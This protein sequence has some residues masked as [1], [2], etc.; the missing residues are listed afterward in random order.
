MLSKLIESWL[1]SASE[2]SYQPAFCQMLI[3][4][5]YTVIHSTRH[6]PIEYGKDVLAIASD[7]IPC[8]FQLKGNP[9][10]SLTLSQY[11]EVR[12]QLD[13]M[14]NQRIEHPSISPDLPHRSYLVTNGRIEEE[15][16]QAIS[17]A[18]AT[19][20]RDGYPN[21]K[22]ETIAR[23]QLLGWALELEESLWPSELSELRILLEIIT[24]KGDELF[25]IDK[26]HALLA[27]LFKLSTEDQQ[28]IG[29]P[30]FARRLSSAALL[31]AVALKPFSERGNHWA[32]TVAWVMFAVYASGYADKYQK[33]TDRLI[34][35]LKI[36]EEAIAVSL[37][38]LLDEA[39][40]RNGRYWE[41]NGVADFPIYTWRYTLIMSIGS[42]YWLESE[43][44]S[45]WPSPHLKAS[46]EA[47]LPA[48]QAEMRLWGEG[49]IPQFLLHEWYLKAAGLDAGNQHIIGLAR[50]IINKPLFCAYYS[51]DEVI[52]H[53][54]SLTFEAFAS[55]ITQDMEG[56]AKSSYFAEAMMVHLAQRNL[57]EACETLWRRYTHVASLAFLPAKKWMYCLSHAEEGDNHMNL[58][59]ETGQWID[60]VAASESDIQKTVPTALAQ[61]PLLLALW[62][63][64]APPRAVTSVICHLYKRFVVRDGV[65]SAAA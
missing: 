50:T 10:S 25:P 57:K 11:R 48:T 40:K 24:F 32:V 41:G 5:G 52:R 21:R 27:S 31:T 36:A 1:D 61:R 34:P 12:P 56:Q 16:F 3:S 35:S 47:M 60:L 19:N 39:S 53:E 18:N 59:P 7:G 9:G 14:V 55:K 4:R 62:C 6:C 51:A 42:L 58:P 43:R 15:V 37:E 46:L 2:R 63:L 30:E 17:Q 65:V 64:I 49:A 8:A 13:E 28:T 54:L 20:E 38:A 33:G 23:E 26:F 22:L 44:T 45:C 29:N